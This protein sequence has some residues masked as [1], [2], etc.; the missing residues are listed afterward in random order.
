MFYVITDTAPGL[1]YNLR[2]WSVS[3]E[4]IRCIFDDN[5]KKFFF[6]FS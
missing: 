5:S 6:K 3:A 2:P 1:L 4:E